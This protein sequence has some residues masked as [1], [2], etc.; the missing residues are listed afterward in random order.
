MFLQ[1]RPGIIEQ[2]LEHRA[3]REHGGP[4]IDVGTLHRD[5]AQLATGSGGAL[6]HRDLA[7]RAGKVDGCGEAAHPAAD[8]DHAMHGDGAVRSGARSRPPRDVL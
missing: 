4:C 3:Q 7:S 2:G 8:D 6:E 5:L 1:T